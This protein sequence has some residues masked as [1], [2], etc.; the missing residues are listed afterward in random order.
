MTQAETVY[1]ENPKES[2]P[3]LQERE[4]LIARMK[5]LEKSSVRARSRNK[6]RQPSTIAGLAMVVAGIIALALSVYASSTILVFMGLGLTFWGALLLFIRQQ[7]YVKSVLIDSTALSSLRTIDRI[8]T[9][10]GY[11]EKG[12]YIPGGNP[13][14]AVVF[15]PQEPFGRI[16]KANEI[17]D[18]TFI[19]NPKGLAMVPPRPRVSHLD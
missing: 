6:R 4:E 15:V 2:E 11:H 14:R 9:N 13:E 16:P 5:E 19:E 18:Q 8:M 17:E 7:K 10:L 1:A 12:I 3:G